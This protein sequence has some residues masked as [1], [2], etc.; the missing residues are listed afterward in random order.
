VIGWISH[1]IA[2]K[3]AEKK[4]IRALGETLTE[5]GFKELGGVCSDVA[6]EDFAGA[7]KKIE[8]LAQQL[9][10]PVTRTALLS[11]VGFAQVPTILADASNCKKL[12][13]TLFDWQ[14]AHPELA[15]AAGFAIATVPVVV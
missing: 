11:S 8:Y 3:V 14:A 5:F 15:K 4:K 12:L 10:D 6:D 9:R 2:W 7:V 1:I 13:K